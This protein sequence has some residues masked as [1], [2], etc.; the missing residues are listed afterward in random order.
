M[1]KIRNAIF[2]ATTVAG[3]FYAGDPESCAGDYLGGDTHTVE[4]FVYSTWGAA[5]EYR[6]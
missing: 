5:G 2:K 6:R 4:M 3:N 1:L